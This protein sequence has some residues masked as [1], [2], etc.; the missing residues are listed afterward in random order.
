V[1]TQR[2][3]SAA[4]CTG[5]FSIASA[6]ARN[7]GKG[8]RSWEIRMANA[9]EQMPSIKIP[10]DQKPDAMKGKPPMSKSRY[11]DGSLRIRHLNVLLCGGPAAET[12]DMVLRWPPV[13]SGYLLGM[14]FGVLRSLMRAT[15][16]SHSG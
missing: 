12:V 2:F 1:A 7:C 6:G 9:I 4:Y 15:T 16:R 11:L 5:A 13:R 3:N 8:M 10:T 14:T